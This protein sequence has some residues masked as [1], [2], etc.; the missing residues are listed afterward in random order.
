M[1]DA[2]YKQVNAK[3]AQ[4]LVE[5][6]V[7]SAQD[8]D[9]AVSSAEVAA[10]T[11]Q[12]IEMQKGYEVLRAPF[13]GTITARFCDPGA[14]LQN[15]GGAQSG[16]LPIVTVSQIDTL[17]I[18]GYVDQR[19]AAFI[20]VGDVA[21]VILAERPGQPIA[22]KV[23]RLA[24]ELDPRTRMM[25]VEI[26]VDNHT[27][28]IVP[29]SYVDI[30]LHLPVPTYVEVPASALIMHGPNP[31]VPVVDDQNQINFHPVELASDDG[32]NLHLLRGIEEG[33]RVA[34]NLG[35]GIPDGSKVQPVALAPPGGPDVAK[36]K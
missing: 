20:K 21:E 11:Q 12:S 1:A 10:A 26:D 33:Q 9:V 16:A 35:D 32:Q 4:A 7:V 17:R 5:P 29:G 31:F 34:L 13:D 14:L 8:R 19:D 28:Q 25:L 23:T 22:A 27:R 24:G 30:V 6:G 2:K 18:Y 15:A 3:R 36:P